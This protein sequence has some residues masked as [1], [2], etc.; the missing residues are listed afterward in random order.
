MKRP[1]LLA[2]FCILASP[3]LNQSWAQNTS[4]APGWTLADTQPDTGGRAP[5][6]PG[7]KVLPPGSSPLSV[8]A[9]CS[10]DIDRIC[11]GRSGLYSA[12][13]CLTENKAR[14]SPRC[15][16][17]LAKLP[18]SSVPPCSRSP[19]CDNRLGPT[20]EQL[21]RVLWKTGSVSYSYPFTL[22]VGGGATGVGIDSRG[23]FWVLQRAV[24]G[25]PQLFQF[26]PDHKLL[27]TVPNSVIGALEKGHTIKVDAADNVW[28]SDANGGIVLKLSPEG[29]LLMTLGVR[30][31]RGDWSEK[32]RLLWQPLDVAF[33]ANG[34]IFIAQGHGNE[35][36]NDV[37]LASDNMV[38]AARVLHLDKN[39][40]FINQWYGNQIGPGKFGSAH[41]IA[42]DPKNGDVWIGDREEYR[43]VVYG[44]DGK[45]KRTI[46]MRNLMS[47]VAFDPRG[48][49]W[50]SSGRD[51]QL[52]KLD[53]NGN[54]LSAV[55]NGSGLGTGQFVESTY[56]AWD[57]SGAVYSGDT[58]VGRVTK[59]VSR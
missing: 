32:H 13:A 38:G 48:E 43:L 39:G 51:G 52:L 9:G 27:R 26:G 2:V 58:S 1:I 24:P 45:H 42:V 6:A 7:G 49:L 46:Q 25:Q 44:K 31:K 18:P 14:L 16:V 30:G 55:G 8:L 36:P 3:G 21:K 20:R 47:A 19:L 53:R 56:M 12:R 59:M 11:Q 5:V 37:G 40:K 34:D 33:A 4:P 54:V 23:N 15:V 22:P 10:G 28:I 35:S 17:D 50:V 41:G 29:K 57:K